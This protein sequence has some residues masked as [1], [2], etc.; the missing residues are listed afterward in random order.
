M[1]D[2]TLKPLGEATYKKAMFT[3]YDAS[4][5]ADS[6]KTSFDMDA[7]FVLAL[8]Y[9]RK[10]SSEQITKAAI[11]EMARF[12][13]KDKEDFADIEPIFLECFSDVKK[14]DQIVAVSDNETKARFY[15]NGEIACS[16]DYPEFREL[17]FGI[18]LGTETRVPKQA[19]LLKGEVV[20]AP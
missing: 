5:C 4:L 20:K 2:V 15:Y 11:H 3:L 7:P 9:R 8:D 13:R 10:F 14:G 17:F 1:D 16:V 18:W 6:K 12:A 19:A